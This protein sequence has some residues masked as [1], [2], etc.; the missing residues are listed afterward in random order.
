MERSSAG[1][2]STDRLL[3]VVPSEY[4]LLWDRWSVR[5]CDGS[6]GDD[7]CARRVG[8]TEAD[9]AKYVCWE[10]PAGVSGLERRL[11]FCRQEGGDRRRRRRSWSWQE[12]CSNDPLEGRTTS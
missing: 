9:G 12:R 2:V 10:R 5:R 6:R 3:L 7:E 4:V 8:L 1:V 11:G